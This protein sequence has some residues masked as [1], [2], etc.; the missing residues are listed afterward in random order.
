[1]HELWVVEGD[2]VDFLVLSAPATP[3]FW[4][5]CKDDVGGMLIGELILNSPDYWPS[6]RLLRSRRRLTSRRRRR[7]LLALGD[8]R[9]PVAFPGRVV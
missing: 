5:A 9:E 7:Y 3:I 8:P 2:Y 4:L 1:M 6:G